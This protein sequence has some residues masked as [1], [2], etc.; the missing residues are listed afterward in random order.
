LLFS[1]VTWS[2]LVRTKGFFVVG[3]IAGAAGFIFIIVSTRTLDVV[4]ELAL[5]R[6]LSGFIFGMLIF[7]IA[8]GP[9][10]ECRRRWKTDPLRRSEIDPP[11]RG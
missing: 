3:A 7:R 1:I 2:G 8:S 11:G 4:S 10:G 6:C 9:W 5:T